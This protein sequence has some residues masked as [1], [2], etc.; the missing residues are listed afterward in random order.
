M[1]GKYCEKLLR[2]DPPVVIKVFPTAAA[3]IDLISIRDHSIEQFGTE[4]G[5]AYMQGFDKAFALLQDHPF[6]GAATPE[7]GN[8]FRCLVH[9][10]HRIFHI[11]EGETVLIVRILH[12]AMDAQQALRS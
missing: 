7:Y 2:N 4:I 6:S 5:Q 1:Q 11:V 10:K 9:R 3:R 8:T 12:H